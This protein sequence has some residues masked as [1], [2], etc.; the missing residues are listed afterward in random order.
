M[1]GGAAGVLWRYQQWSPSWLQSLI[2]LRIRNQLKTARNGIFFAWNEHFAWFWPQEL[3]L[4]MKEVENTRIYLRICKF[5]PPATAVQARGVDGTPP[6]SFWYV[7]VFWNDLAFSKKPLIF[8]T[9]CSI[10]YGWWR[11]WRPVT[12]ATMVAF[13]AAIFDFT[14]NPKSA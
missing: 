6:R 5:I 9:R 11:C 10:L 7:A 12:S 3:L 4:P 14:K 13:L 8:L 1:G 2:L